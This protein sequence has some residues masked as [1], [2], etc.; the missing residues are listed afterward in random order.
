MSEQPDS[1]LSSERETQTVIPEWLS[2]CEYKVASAVVERLDQHFWHSKLGGQCMGDYLG[3]PT[4]FSAQISDCNVCVS[5]MSC[6]FTIASFIISYRAV[7][8]SFS[9]FSF[10]VLRV[11]L[12]RGLLRFFFFLLGVAVP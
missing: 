6:K 9:F 5:F 12:S 8:F 3:S 10:R 2:P 11:S 4:P 1:S 7:V